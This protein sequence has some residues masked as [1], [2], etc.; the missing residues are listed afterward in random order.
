MSY[1]PPFLSSLNASS[2]PFLH[3]PFSPWFHPAETLCPGYFSRVKVLMD[4]DLI[5]QKF[6]AGFYRN[7]P[8]FRADAL[9][10]FDNA[11]S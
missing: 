6:D 2:L 10:L 4:L 3:S 11:I 5:Q 7:L 8:A 9:L 1:L